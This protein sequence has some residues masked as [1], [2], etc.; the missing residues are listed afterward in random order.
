MPTFL[1]AGTMSG[2]VQSGSFN[3]RPCLERAVMSGILQL[4][5]RKRMESLESTSSWMHGKIYDVPTSAVL[6]L[7]RITTLIVEEWWDKSD[8]AGPKTRSRPTEQEPLP[9]LQVVCVE[10]GSCTFL[11]MH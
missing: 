8:A 7:L 3:L 10:N 11:D 4:F 1:P 5:E 2:A 6:K 9:T